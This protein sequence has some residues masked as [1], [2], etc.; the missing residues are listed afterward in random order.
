AAEL[1]DDAARADCDLIV[2]DQAYAG[3]AEKLVDHIPADRMTEILEPYREVPLDRADGVT[4]DSLLMLIFTSGTS[5]RARAVRVTHRKVVV[6]GESLA[7]RLL[8]PDDVVYCPMPLF[9]SGAVMAAYAPALVAGATL[10]LRR[11]FSASGLLPDVR[12]YGCTYMQYVGK[13][14]SHVL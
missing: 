13:A 11:R 5:G 10:V 3:L 2:V 9:H 1:A 12:T 6:P 14:L 8:K 7:R 4:A